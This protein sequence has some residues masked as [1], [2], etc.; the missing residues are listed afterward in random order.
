[1]GRQF[2]F[3]PSSL[4]V[5][6]KEHEDLRLM[7]VGAD[8]TEKAALGPYQDIAMVV[9]TSLPALGL[10]DPELWPSCCRRLL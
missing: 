6:E 7:R 3:S 9:P 1:M 5:T 4:S 10:L 8:H 2:P